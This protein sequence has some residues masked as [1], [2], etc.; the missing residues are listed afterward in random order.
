MIAQSGFGVE[1]EGKDCA[2]PA[3]LFLPDPPDERAGPSTLRQLRAPE[4][5]IA[6]TAAV[7]SEEE[8]LCNKTV[9]FSVR[10]DEGG[11]FYDIH[12]LLSVI[13]VLDPF[14]L[15]EIDTLRH[16]VYDVVHA[17]HVYGTDYSLVKGDCRKGEGFT[18]RALEVDLLEYPFQD[19]KLIRRPDELE[20]LLQIEKQSIAL[21][22]EMCLFFS[23]FDD[24]ELHISFLKDSM[25]RRIP[26]P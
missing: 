22:V 7:K 26:S 19:T 8:L 6:F 10:L 13:R 9:E 21:F 17:I 5:T 14:F 4:N 1:C 11:I 16:P 20:I 3:A 25:K 24:E 2:Y 12:A 23:Q 18:L 15:G